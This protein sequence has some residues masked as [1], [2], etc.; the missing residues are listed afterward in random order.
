MSPK[1]SPFVHALIS[2][3]ILVTGLLAWG[4]LRKS[5]LDDSSQQLAIS[6]TQAIFVDGNLDPLI[7]NAHASLI[8]QYS[9]ENLRRTLLSISEI[10]GPL[11][12]I[13]SI[14]GATNVSFIP[15]LGGAP[16]ASYA[17]S[18]SFN[19]NIAPIIIEM[20]QEGGSW[21]FTT[22]RVDSPMLLN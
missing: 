4:I 8:E 15:F 22:Y 18:S 16:T 12:L 20:L 9:E 5:N 21:K 10:L 6:V 7:P 17:I 14:N 11:E 1:F 3:L 13:E 19:E 2:G